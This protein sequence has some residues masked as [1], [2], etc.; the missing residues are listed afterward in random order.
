MISIDEKTVA[1][2]SVEHVKDFLL[3]ID[4]SDGTT[5]TVEFKLFLESSK[6]PDIRNYLN[7]EKFSQYT[8]TDGILH[9]NDYEL[10]FPMADLYAGKIKNG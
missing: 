9:W 1:I 10:I 6:H 2:N 7:I 4:F 3:R 5:K 8:V